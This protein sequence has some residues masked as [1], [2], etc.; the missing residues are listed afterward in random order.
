MREK[1]G[2]FVESRPFNVFIIV[3]III[4][5][6][7]L[8]LVYYQMP[9]QLQKALNIGNLIFTVIFACEMVLKLVGLG[10][11]N[12]IKDTFN[13]FDAIVVI[14]GLLE[15]LNVKSKAVTVFRA[16]RLLRIFKIV[17]SWKTLKRLLQVVLKSFSALGNLAL[18]M[19]LFCFIYGLIGYSFLNG[20]MPDINGI[21]TP[22]V[23]TDFGQSMLSIWV[24]LT[25]ENCN[26]QI[27]A[28][29]HK[30]GYI[31][32]IFYVSNIILGNMMLLNMFLAIFLNFISSN[33]EDEEERD[34]DQKQLEQDNAMILEEH[35]YYREKFVDNNA[36]NNNS[37]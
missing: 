5:T 34:K 26:T 19:A 35:V 14:I 6:I 22:Y 37:N 13:D 2:N 7:F 28:G 10:I 23:F 33:M 4:N 15:F 31:S 18:L 24:L 12:Y 11:K 3:M 1:I 29:V 36:H 16:F 9:D 32:L 8:S 21:P 17:K 25:G 30:K 20:P 27:Y